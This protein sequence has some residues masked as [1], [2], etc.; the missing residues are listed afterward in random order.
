MAHSVYSTTCIKRAGDQFGLGATQIHLRCAQKNDF[1][2]FI[3]SD[4]D[5]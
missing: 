5:L 1:Y 3:P 2:I 4:L